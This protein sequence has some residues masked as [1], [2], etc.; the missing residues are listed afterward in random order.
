MQPLQITR[1]RAIEAMQ[2]TLDDDESSEFVSEEFP[3][4]KSNRV[5]VQN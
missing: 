3:S 4:S 2:E 5:K 1:P